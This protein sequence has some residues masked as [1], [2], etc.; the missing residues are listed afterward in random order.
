MRDVRRGFVFVK[1]RNGERE[2]EMKILGL[3]GGIASGKSTV[4][5]MLRSAGIDVVD[6]D[7]L[8]RD[9]VAP[10]SEGLAAIVDAFTPAILLQ[11]GSLDRAQLG[12]IIFNDAVARKRLNTIVHPRVAALGAERFVALG[13]AGR[14][15]AVYEVPLLF[16]NGLEAAMA[17]T[18]LVST[19]V[20]VQRAR[21]QARDDLSAA[22]AQARIDAQMPLSEKA[23]RADV[24][25][26]NSGDL[27][28]T[29]RQLAAAWKQVTGAELPSPRGPNT[30]FFK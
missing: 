6:A 29:R 15:V 27:E 12:D 18:L 26:D 13:D 30:L 4:A 21:L 22:D 16:E 5:G 28:Q 24:V 7:Q 14:D 17:A 2:T 3:T 8:A 23:K 9:V 10:G 25:I 20:D 19:P 1:R 11:D